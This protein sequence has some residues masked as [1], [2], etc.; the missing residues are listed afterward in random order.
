MFS[1]LLFHWRFVQLCRPFDTFHHSKPK[2]ILAPKNLE[3]ENELLGPFGNVVL[4]M[5]FVFFENMYGW[6]NVC[7][8]KYNWKNVCKN[9]CNII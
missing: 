3:T 9:T 1:I 6:K 8:N 7:K 5:L 2:L 4:V